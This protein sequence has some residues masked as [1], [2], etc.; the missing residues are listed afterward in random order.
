MGVEPNISKFNRIG[1]KR[2]PG[3]NV[4]PRLLKLVLASEHDKALL[5]HNCTKLR[6]K[7][8]PDDVRK[9]YVT[10]DLTPREQQKSKAL[11]AQLFEMNKEGKNYWIKMS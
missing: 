4:Q 1:K 10:P 6:S 7:D 3:P 5:L 9:V 11:R 2:D 8:N